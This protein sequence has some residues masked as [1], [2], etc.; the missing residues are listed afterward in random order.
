MDQAALED[1]MA[2]SPG[3]NPTVLLKNLYKTPLAPLIRTNQEKIL[4]HSIRTNR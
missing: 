1:L 3:P 2:P 4:N